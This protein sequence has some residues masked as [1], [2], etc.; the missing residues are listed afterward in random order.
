MS[1]VRDRLAW[2]RAPW[3]ALSDL[4]RDVARHGAAIERLLVR[5]GE[6]EIQ[7]AERDAGG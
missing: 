3:V 7:L 4:Q 1:W 6:L 5:V 2:L